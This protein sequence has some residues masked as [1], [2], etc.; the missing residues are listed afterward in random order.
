MCEV[1]A[2][3]KSSKRLINLDLRIKELEIEKR[4]MM[5]KFAEMSHELILLKRKRVE[6][7]LDRAARLNGGDQKRLQKGT[8]NFLSDCKLTL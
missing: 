3:Y 8:C 2:F 5:Y 7:I 6:L 4:Y 1:C